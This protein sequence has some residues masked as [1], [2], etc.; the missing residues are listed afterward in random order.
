MIILSSVL[1][2]FLISL[3]GGFLSFIIPHN[4]Q[5]FINYVLT[6]TGAYL[7]SLVILHLLPHTIEH[8]GTQALIW[9]LIGFLIQFV[10]QQFSHGVEHGHA[11]HHAH[12][13]LKEFAVIAVGLSI[14][15]L[16]EGI[17]LAETQVNQATFLSFLFGIGIHKLPE[18]FALACLA[19]HAFHIK[20][21]RIAIIVGFSLL[22][23]I[24]ILFFAES[25]VVQGRFFQ[26]LFPLVTGAVM[27]IA[28]SIIY[29]TAGNNHKLKLIKLLLLLIGFSMGLLS[30][31]IHF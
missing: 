11:H 26:Y 24:S 3:L 31:F 19:S 7:L 23:P 1:L 4:K 14:H 22:T 29:E 21:Q 13:P 30:L 12:L 9:V 16:S 5:Q 2:I 6:I 27:Q 15:A 25:E 28:T 8:Y 17:P 18:A 20:A 10:L